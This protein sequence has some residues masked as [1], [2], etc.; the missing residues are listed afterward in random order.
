MATLNLD[1]TPV[2][3]KNLQAYEDPNV[4]L[5][6]NE[7]G[8]RSSKTYS[9]CQLGAFLPFKYNLSGKIFDICRKT[10]SELHDT[11]MRDFFQIL[12]DNKLYDRRKHNKTYHEYE[13]RGMLFRFLGLDKA[14]KKRGTK[15]DILYVNEANGITLEDWIQLNIRLAGKAFVDHNPSETYWVHDLI[16]RRNDVR[17]IKSTYLD[18]YDFL[19]PKQI[20]EIED[21][22]NVDDFYYQVYTL[23]NLAAM[24]GQI[25]TPWDG[26][27]GY[28]TI[29]AEAYNFID[30]QERFY[31]LDWG[32]EHPAALVEIKYAQE[33]VYTKQLFHKSH[34]TDDQFIEWMITNNV[35]Q[36]DAIYADPAYPASISKARDAGFNV[37]KAKKDVHDGIRF[38]QSLPTFI[39]NDSHDF[40]KNRKKYKWRQKSDGTLIMEPVK[41]MDDIEDA[42]RYGAYTRLKYEAA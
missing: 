38:C 2:F 21:L 29:D 3:T 34:H 15:R 4:T 26:R 32:Y 5:I 7:G 40:L 10:Q 13:H 18:N 33:K 42:F 19:T 16:D 31:G 22:Q 28:Q 20:A 17:V 25:Y 41:I 36:T 12:E 14:Q 9:I 24:K 30:Y 11:V 6:V 39:T 37:F 8:T 35:S 27:K 23:G 1:V